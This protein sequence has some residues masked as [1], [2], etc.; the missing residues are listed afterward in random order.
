MVTNNSINSLFPVDVPSGGTG[1]ATLTSHG[2]LLGNG[3]SAISATT[4][5]TNGQLLIGNTGA[6]PSVAALTAGSGISITN[7]AG[8]ITIAQSAVP[9][10]GLVWNDQTTT[11]VTMAAGNAYIADNAALVTLTLPGTAALGDVFAVQGKGAGLWTIAQAAGQT[12]HF[13]SV[14][15]TAGVGGSLSATNQYDAIELVC[16][17]AN[18]TFAVRFAIGNITYV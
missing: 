5:L 12:I 8:S 18:T 15:T 13:G 9:G 14:A 17:T 6:A 4:A 2:V 1:V 11:S 3:A 16:I 10:A 7:G